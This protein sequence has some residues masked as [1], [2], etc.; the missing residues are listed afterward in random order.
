MRQSDIE[1][2]RHAT[3]QYIPHLQN[4]L[5]RYA[6]EKID[7]DLH[8][9]TR[10][11][12]LATAALQ[13]AL[14]ELDGIEM[15][16]KIIHSEKPR[17]LNFRRPNHVILQSGDTILDLTPNQFLE[18]IGLTAEKASTEELRHLYPVEKVWVYDT[19]KA[20]TRANA[21]ARYA[22]YLD[23]SNAVPLT[24][25]EYGTVGAL[26]GASVDEMHKVYQ[27][28]WNPDNYK[29]FPLTKQRRLFRHIGNELIELYKQDS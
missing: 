1:K 20:L 11:C 26:R 24:A 17:G 27:A 15:D 7:T 25:P 23:S 14:R 8:L 13:P 19:D 2:I 4:V 10:N 12:G 21:F 29:P 5:S 9:N 6:L 22:Y 16:R 28:I 18:Y 3:E